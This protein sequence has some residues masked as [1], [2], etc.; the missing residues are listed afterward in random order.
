MNLK[1]KADSLD[2]KK[3]AEQLGVMS[4]ESWCADVKLSVWKKVGVRMSGNLYATIIQSCVITLE[5]LLSEVED[6][7]GCIFVPSSSKFLY[8]NGDTSGKKNVV[9]IREPD[10]LPF[11]E[12]GVIDIGAVI[13][14]FTAIAINPYPKKEGITFSNIYDTDQLKN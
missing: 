8:P 2:C 4:V 7:L 13:A 10:I 9:V 12:D 1:L 5:P 3:L 11:S 14:D 6:T